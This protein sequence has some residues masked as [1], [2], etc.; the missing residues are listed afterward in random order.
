MM[1]RQVKIKYGIIAGIFLVTLILWA[2]ALKACM[3][4]VLAGYSR[5]ASGHILRAVPG[6]YFFLLWPCGLSCQKRDDPYGKALFMLCAGGGDHLYVYHAALIRA[7]DEFAHYATADRWSNVMMLREDTD[8]NGNVYMRAED[9][10][11]VGNDAAFLNSKENY[12]RV[13]EGF[14]KPCQDQET[15]VFEYKLVSSGPIP[16]LAQA[17]GI[18]IGRLLGTGWALT[19][20]LGRL[21][22]LAL[23]SVCGFFCREMDPLREKDP[24]CHIHASDDAGNGLLLIL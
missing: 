16:Y 22:N 14:L 10:E 15:T 11:A 13:M 17:L 2:T 6:L 7:P 23:F 21:M 24:V 20:F 8:E 1:D 9:A 19:I 18:T 5:P 12:M 4:P 3:Y